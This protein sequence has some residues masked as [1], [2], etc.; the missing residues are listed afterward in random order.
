MRRF[1]R[2]PETLSKLA[3]QTLTIRKILMLR[4]LGRAI[5]RRLTVTTAA[6]NGAYNTTLYY[7]VLQRVSLRSHFST[8]CARIANNASEI[9]TILGY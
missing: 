1:K 8:L 2:V 7:L 3:S 6:L 5:R 9:N 4:F